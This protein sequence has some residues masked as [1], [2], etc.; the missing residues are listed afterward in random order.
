MNGHELQMFD[1]TWVGV[2]AAIVG[3]IYVVFAAR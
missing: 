2:P 1:I 3:G